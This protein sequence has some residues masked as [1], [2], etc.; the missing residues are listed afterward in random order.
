MTSRAV[1]F[2]PDA[3]AEARAAFTWY[4]Q[5]D[6]R[7]AAAFL[8]EL[9]QAVARVLESPHIWPRYDGGTRRCLFDRFPFFLVYRERTDRIEVLAVA[10][11]KRR[12]GFWRER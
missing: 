6:P 5:K 1:E 4:E 12:P 11:G 3:V 2:H 9:D 10:H 8:G 7:T